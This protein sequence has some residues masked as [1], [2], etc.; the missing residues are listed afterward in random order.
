MVNDTESGCSKSDTATVL[1]DIEMPTAVVGEEAQL[2]CLNPFLIL[3]AGGTSQGADLTYFWSTL[4]GNIVS[5][6]T[7]L[8]PK[9]DEPG[10]YEFEVFN[11][12]NGCSDR[13]SVVITF[14]EKVPESVSFDLKQPCFG[15]IRGS[16]FIDSV[17]SGNPP[18]YFSIDQ[19]FFFTSQIF[20]PVPIG[21][22]TLTIRDEIG[23][24]LDTTFSI[25]EL[26]E[27]ILDLE[28]ELE[29]KLGES[30]TLPALVNRNESDLS[31]IQWIPNEKLN[32]DDCLNPIATPFKSTLYKL[33]IADE[34]GCETSASV[35]V[36]VNLQACVYIPNAFSPNGD[37]TNDI[38]FINGVQNIERV[39]KFRVFNRWGELVFERR[40]F[41]PNDPE[42]GWDGTH[43]GRGLNTGV[44]TWMAESEFIDGR[45]ELFA[46][47]VNLLK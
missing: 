40:D 32:C 42:L 2:N 5:D 27:L 14:N 18:F 26:E 28:P 24:E 11:E 36:K 9:I 45:K 34:N 8:F 46:G 4:D 38:F 39:I 16:L 35:N 41:A 44:F 13:D 10:L 23:C 47:D 3:D 19:K 31:E 37:G 20:D 7:T 22:Y 17:E 6:E 30:V 25:F 1:E 12:R 43:R 33:N 15:E 29:I 21:N